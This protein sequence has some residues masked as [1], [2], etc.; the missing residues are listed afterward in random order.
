MKLVTA[1]FL[2]IVFIIAG[3]VLGSLAAEFIKWLYKE[4][5]NE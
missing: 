3:S 5:F 1:L 4:A 2:G